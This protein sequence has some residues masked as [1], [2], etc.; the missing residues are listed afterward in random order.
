MDEI[1]ADDTS[2]STNDI[3]AAALERYEYGQERDRQNREDAYDDL[4]FRA[5]DT[6]PTDIEDARRREGRP[7]LNIPIIG[8]YV[9]Q[10]TGDIR[11]MRPALKVAPVDDRG[12]PETA[13]ILAGLFRYIEGRS[14]ASSV[15][16]KAADSQVACGAGAWRV[17]TEYADDSTF[18]QEIRVASIEDP[19]SVVWDPDAIEQDRSDAQWVFVP[20]DMS[21][22]AF[23]AAYPGKGQSSFGDGDEHAYGGAADWYGEDYIRVAE[24]WYR[25][26]IKRMLMVMP[27]G[28]VDDLTDF[29]P[30]DPDWSSQVEMGMA[31]GAVVEERDSTR[32]MRAVISGSEILEGPDPWPGRLIPIVPVWG[33]EIRIG[34]RIV[35]HGLVR[36]I[37]DPQRRYNYMVS[38]ETEILA[39][40]PKAPFIGTERNFARHQEW[41]ATA[42][43]AAYSYLPYDPDPEN[44]GS[45]PARAMP[46]V[47]SQGIL[48]AIQRAA[49]DVQ[50]VTGIYN[51]SLGA[52]SN[53]KSGRA[54]D[55]RKVEGDTG[56]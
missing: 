50:A 45:A 38:A 3:H 48:E 30:E 18:N 40:Q 25:E 32:V 17:V 5:G 29:D 21:L 36:H 10:V 6:W 23:K 24:Y 4:R 22:A 8:Q 42:N 31:R 19:V 47:A 35:R 56:T 26:P 28:S 14:A 7:C 46:P 20:V 2:T 16:F 41:W 39:L 37:K 55:A 49:S 15:Y 9:R 34:R 54:I 27:D 33:E 51:A 1:M 44:G 43:T 11:K 53:E 13:D 52:A 12:D